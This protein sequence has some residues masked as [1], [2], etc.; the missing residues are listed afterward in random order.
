LVKRERISPFAEEPT[1]VFAR[2]G[3][4]ESRGARDQV[5]RSLESN[6]V[7]GIRLP[8]S[9]APDGPQQGGDESY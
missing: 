8:L 3:S 1:E 5:C 6:G 7:G 2:I 9:T 4:E